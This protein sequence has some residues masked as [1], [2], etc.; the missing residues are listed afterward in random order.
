MLPR[1][2]IVEIKKVVGVRAVHHY[3]GQSS[4]RI[5]PLKK[6]TLLRALRHSYR[7]WIMHSKESARGN[8]G[9]TRKRNI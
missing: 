7:I 3:R 9:P 2:Y 8:E 1:D 5:H 4:F 6:T